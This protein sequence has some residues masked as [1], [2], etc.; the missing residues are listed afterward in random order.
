MMIPAY[1]SPLFDHLWQSTLLAGMVGLLT[2]A[3]RKNQA[4]ARHRLWLIASVKFLIPC[5]LLVAMGGHWGW[6]SAHRVIQPRL[7]VAVQEVSQPFTTPVTLLPAQGAIASGAESKIPMALFVVWACGLLAVAFSWWRRWRRIRGVVN[8]ALPVAIEAEVPVLSSPTLL[9]PGVFGIFRPVLLLPEGIIERLAPAQLEAIL[10]H[11]M[12]HV[13]RRDNLAAAIHMFIE[14]VFWF[15]PLVW[16][17]GTR[18][19][20]ERERACDEEVLQSGSEPQTYAEG[21]L[22]TCEFYL[23]SPLACMSGVTGADLKKR[24]VRIMTQRIV[25]KLDPGRKLLLSAAGI[26]AVAGPIVIGLM[27]APGSRAQSQAD[28]ASKPAFEVASIK[29][30]KSGSG[31]VMFRMAPG[32]RF[33][34]NNITVKLLIE[35][36]YGLKDSQISGGPSWINSDRYDIEAKPDESSVDKMQKLS[37]DERTKQ[38]EAMM[39][40]LLAD[41]FKLTLRHETKELPIYV[42]SVAKN[43]PKLQ[44]AKDTP[45]PPELPNPEGPNGPAPRGPRFMM[46]DRGEL[47]VNDAP[48]SML[49]DMLSRQ[50]GRLVVDKTGLKGKFDFTLKWTPDENQT[51]AFM[52][53][54][55]AGDPRPPSDAAPPPS[56][57]GPSLFTALQEQLGLKLESQK[58][59]V[60]TLVI[61]NVEKPS[62]N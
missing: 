9:E 35:Q 13:R 43:G 42:L 4:Q 59:P 40:S 55:G 20:E 16:W 51:Q 48:V 54:A 30:D 44:Q 14:A 5:S 50:L 24:I 6:V 23:E 21:I 46:S 38:L 45:L 22:K 2:L 57:S 8:A 53:A 41:R 60:E 52:G 18:L 39:Q 62:E 33:V 49:A 19:M 3:L 27:N 28:A 25:R 7:S 29:P 32:G 1:L 56:A 47:T 37:Q 15:H 26:A 11:E 31:Q 58:G 36:A 34:A 10:T 61:D 17:I 12:C